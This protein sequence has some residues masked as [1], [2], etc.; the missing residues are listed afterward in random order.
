[1]ALPPELHLGNL[2]YHEACRPRNF[3]HLEHNWATLWK[4]PGAGT[5]TVMLG[6]GFSRNALPAVMG[7]RRLPPSPCKNASKQRR[8]TGD[9]KS[10]GRDSIIHFD[11]ALNYQAWAGGI[12][13][14]L[15]TTLTQK[16]I[17]LPGSLKR[18]RAICANEILPN[19]RSAWSK[20]DSI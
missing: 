6:A 13:S 17:S 10:S 4:T 15:A 19:V 1:M 16:S 8:T 14:D 11:R 12:A 20:K 2:A 3:T 7:A 18:S 5:V 9:T